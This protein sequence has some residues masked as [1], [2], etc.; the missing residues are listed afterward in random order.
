MSDCVVQ[1]PRELLAL[2]DPDVVPGAMLGARGEPDGQAEHLR[3]AEHDEPADRVREGRARV[4][5]RS[6]GRRPASTTTVPSDDVAA[7]SPTAAA[8][9]AAAGRTPWR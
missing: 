8:R 5:G 4:A 1:I 6:R 3:E 7:R 9:T 2:A